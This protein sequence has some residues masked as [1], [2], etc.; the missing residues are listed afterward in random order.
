ML[1]YGLAVATLGALCA[2]VFRWP[3]M[4]LT[5]LVLACLS[6][7]VSLAAGEGFARSVGTG[8]GA[9]I[10]FE[11]AYVLSGLVSGLGWRG[12]SRKRGLRI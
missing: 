2:F 1:Y 11:A 4:L 6:V 8:L 7:G 12:A 5:G 10:L 9:L 3:A